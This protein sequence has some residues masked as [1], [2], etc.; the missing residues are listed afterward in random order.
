MVAGYERNYGEAER[1]RVVRSR[2]QLGHLKLVVTT[3]WY[4][5]KQHRRRLPVAADPCWLT[6]ASRVAVFRPSSASVNVLTVYA[7][8]TFEC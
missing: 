2:A 6:R 3:N 4:Q 1:N 8:K 7:Q 5:F